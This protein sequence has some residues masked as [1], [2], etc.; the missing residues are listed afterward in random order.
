MQD[1]DDSVVSAW[2][3]NAFVAGVLVLGAL[4]P[5]LGRV[6]ANA[7]EEVVA[8]SRAM[9]QEMRRRHVMRAAAPIPCARLRLVRFG[10]LGFDGKMHDDGEIV[11]LDAVADSVLDIFRSLRAMKFP[12]AKARPMTAYGGDDNVAMADD[13][14]SAF[15]DR[16][17]AGVNALSMHAYGL[18]IDINPVQNPTV[19]RA[20]TF[21][22]LSGARYTN[23][24]HVRPGMAERA[25]DVFADNGFVVWGGRWIHPDYQHFQVDRGIAGR[26]VGLPPS[27]ARAAF[28]R[29]IER[30]RHCRQRSSRAQCRRVVGSR[31]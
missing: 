9:C 15:N 2:R 27:Q 6:H 25:V 16:A 31:P 17:I 22:P 24:R 1:S 3:L 4:T 13:N 20:R 26:L 8:I 29:Y 21:R 5:S 12:V 11:V 28:K 23:R 18:A 14:T 19:R 30:Y 10:Y 7:R